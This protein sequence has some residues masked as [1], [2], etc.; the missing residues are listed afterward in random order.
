MSKIQN[1]SSTELK[2]RIELF[3]NAYSFVVEKKQ[4]GKKE[5]ETYK[6]TAGNSVEN[7]IRVTH[8]L[9]Y[10]V[11][12]AFK[13]WLQ[14]NTKEQAAQK[15]E[16]AGNIGSEIHKVIENCKG[17][18]ALIPEVEHPEVRKGV[19]AFKQFWG[20]MKLTILAQ[21]LQIFSQR[22]GY[23][24]TIDMIAV[25]EHGQI[26]VIDWKSGMY[27]ANYGWQLAAYG[28]AFKEHFGVEPRLMA[29]MLDKR[30]G[31]ASK[32]AYEH[33]SHLE[34]CYLGVLQ[35]F[36]GENWKALGEFWSWNLK[37]FHGI[38]LI[39]AEII[40]PELREEQLEITF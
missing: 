13:A 20:E 28:M 1:I 37:E 30:S 35:A 25:D 18:I 14:S 9:S 22:Y 16:S 29:V 27:K 15:M 23:A 34:A 39:E 31:K 7:Y 10:W 12:P 5:F 24:G 6:I 33:N 26:W 4:V 2:S 40:E 8:P 17:D 36:A 38:R 21:E 32:I 19:E 3:K 11:P